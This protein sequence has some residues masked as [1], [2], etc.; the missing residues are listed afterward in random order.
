VLDIGGRAVELSEIARRQGGL[1]SRAQARAAGMT[2]DAIEARLRA[3]RWQRVF[4][5][6]YATFNGPLPRAATLWAAVL[7]ARPGAMLSHGSAAEVIGL[8][9]V[10]GSAA[11]TVVHVTVP[12]PRRLQSVPGVVVHRSRRAAELK[13]PSRLPPQTRVEETVI[14][15]TQTAG[16]LDGAIGWITKAC[17]QRLTT[18]DRLAAALAA[19]HRVRWRAELAEVLRDVAAGCHSLLELRYLRDVERRHGLPT[20][21]R[22]HAR[23]RAGG[24]WYDDVCYEAYA[25]LVELDGQAAHPADQR[26]R[27]LRRD[28]VGVAEGKS[29]LRYGMG[30]VTE[31]PCEVAG[32]VAVVLLR[33][34]WLGIPIRCGQDCLINEA[35]C[36]GDNPDEAPQQRGDLSPS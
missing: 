5:G 17:A 4:G 34:G 2:D 9:R 12:N 26:W 14:D 36:P 10:Q 30:D 15:L 13:H 28:N 20:G 29:V 3:R 6:V 1:V 11:S 8:S 21:V 18:D 23:P 31:R 25:T 33:S 22:Q 32:Q 27:D 7:W 35:F 16:D 19:R 24:R